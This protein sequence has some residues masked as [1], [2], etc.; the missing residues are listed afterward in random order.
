MKTNNSPSVGL[1]TL[2]CKVA[3]YETEA[4]GEAFVARGFRILPFE[5]KNDVYVINTCT[6]T[7]ESDRKSRQMIRRANRKNPEAPILVTG[8]YSQ[9]DPDAVAKLPGVAVVTGTADKLTLVDHAEH[10][11]REK[12]AE[13]IVS[14]KDVETVDFE[15]MCIA[16]APRTRAYVKIEDGCECRCTYCAIAPARGRVRS[17]KPE[18]VVREVE[19]LY[20]NGTREVVLTGIEIGSYGKDLDTPFTLAD[21][22]CLLNERKSCERVRLGSLAPELVGEEFAERVA[23]LSIL[24][25]HF[26]F[27]VQSGSDA[28]LRGMRRRYTSDRALE[29]IERLR[30]KIPGAMF[31]SDVMVGFPGESEENFLE[32]VDFVEKARFLACHVFAYSRRKGTI[33]DRMPDQIPEA[34]KH[35]RSEILIRKAKEVQSGILDEIVKSGEPLSCVLETEEGGVYTAHSDSYIEFSVPGDRGLQGE[36]RMVLPLSHRDGIVIGKILE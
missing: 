2:G 29:N 14:V 13:K 7:A 31:T 36:I 10:L 3:Q 24:A 18:D 32:T 28:V 23:G 34:E 19:A 33:A 17:K 6:V 22:L 26:H 15:P 9:R 30:K 20:R 12:T 4:I 16:H 21:L 11:L 5:E 1:Y 8:C 25:P 35:R 27:S